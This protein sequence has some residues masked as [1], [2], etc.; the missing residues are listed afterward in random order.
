VNHEQVQD[1]LD[2]YVEAWRNYD[3]EVIRGL[4][5]EDATYAYHPWDEPLQG[6]DAIFEN[7][8]L[9]P[10]EPGSWEAK[11]RPAVVEGNRA[12]TT[13]ITS[14]AAGRSYWNMWELDF[15]D[16]GKCTRFVEW[17]MQVPKMNRD[18]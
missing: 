7:W 16:E 13:G 11:Y 9:T 1:W 18:A 10:D 17:F 2:R 4:F 14:Y 6:V 12:V 15:D 3:S 8:M 5:S